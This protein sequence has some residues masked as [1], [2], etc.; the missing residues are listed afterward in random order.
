MSGLV[1]VIVPAYNAAKSLSRCLDSIIA[2]G[3]SDLEIVVVNDGS[4]DATAQVAQRYSPR[5]I[6]LEQNNQ[7]ETAARNTGFAAAKGDYITFLDHDD[8]WE[9]GFVSEAVRF[10]EENP[11]A[12][13][14]SAGVEHRSALKELPV[15]RPAFLASEAGLPRNPELLSDF[16]S[17][18]AD[19]DHICAGSAMLRAEVIR[20][21]GGQRT[22]L[23]LSGDMEFW[24][25][26]STFGPWGFIPRVLLHVD[27]TQ[28][29]EGKL[30]EKYYARFSR[31]APILSW[32][33][34]VQPVLCE[35]HRAGFDRI[36]ARVALGYIFAYVFVK[37]D[38]EALLAARMFSGRMEG[39]F[40]KLW[41]AASSGGWPAW[42]ATCMLVRFRTK[43]QYAR[44]ERTLAATLKCL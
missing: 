31:C 15:I 12:I 7:G 36:Y 10:L 13:G 5:I 42:R 9:P 25:Y 26:L 23:V 18:W 4:T 22:D 32:A 40:G 1:S 11:A 39:P 29:A 37:R 43:L 8:Y 34:R 16:F 6:Y 33:S 19:H 27:G 44:A 2:Q 17:F 35:N 14:V 30:Y 38:R 21:S 3:Y 28:V 20:A 41:T 24:A